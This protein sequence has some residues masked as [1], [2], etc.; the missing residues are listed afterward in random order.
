MPSRQRS[1]RRWPRSPIPRGRA[2]TPSRALPTYKSLAKL[3]R[4]HRAGQHPGHQHLQLGDLGSAQ[5]RGQHRP[6]PRQ[7]PVRGLRAD[8]RGLRQAA[9]RAARCAQGRSG[10]ADRPGLLP[11]VPRP[12]RP[13]R[14]ARASGPPSRAPRSRSTGKGGDIKVNDTAKVVCGGIQ[15][16]NARIYLI[17]TVLDPTAAPR[18]SRRRDVDRPRRHDTTTTTDDDR[19]RSRRPRSV[20][21]PR[22]RCATRRARQS[23]HAAE[24]TPRA[25]TG[26]GRGR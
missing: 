26:P 18:R 6:G 22:R 12:A 5:S 19:R 20:R 21:P 17:D 10:R 14:R 11:R 16:S 8:Q 9:S 25:A 2:A 23:R 1:R 4:R 15:A 24:S 13:R 7:R 3:A